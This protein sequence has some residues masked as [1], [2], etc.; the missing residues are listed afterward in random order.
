[1]PNKFATRSA[2]EFCIM[3]RIWVRRRR[4]PQSLYYLAVSTL[5]T[6]YTI[7]FN[8]GIYNTFLLRNK[9]CDGCVY[10]RNIYM[11]K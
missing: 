5:V 8:I 4:S 6:S 1:M 2:E 10:K 9:S 3:Q 7:V 11:Y